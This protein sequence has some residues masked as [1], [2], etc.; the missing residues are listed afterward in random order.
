MLAITNPHTLILHAISVTSLMSKA[1]L[2][3]AALV[4]RE[5]LIM[6]RDEFEGTVNPR[7]ACSGVSSHLLH[8]NNKYPFPQTA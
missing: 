3:A 5:D 7:A 2:L 6:E 8:R 4:R 1:I